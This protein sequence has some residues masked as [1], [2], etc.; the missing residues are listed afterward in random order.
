MHQDPALPA[1][2]VDA[3]VAVAEDVFEPLDAFREH[4]EQVRGCVVAYAEVLFDDAEAL[5]HFRPV[6]GERDDVGY[7]VGFENVWRFG[8][9]ETV[10][11]GG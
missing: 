3:V 5:G 6:R 1:V 10:G 7:G 4:G 8:G 11:G 9:G 2:L